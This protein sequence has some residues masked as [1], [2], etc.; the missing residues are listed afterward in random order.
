VAQCSFS[1]C[2]AKQNRFESGF[3]CDSFRSTPDL[4][5]KLVR[6]KEVLFEAKDCFATTILTATQIPHECLTVSIVHQP[7]GVALYFILDD[8]AILLFR[9]TA[10][11][12]FQHAPSR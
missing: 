1:K 9:M 4:L 10:G 7:V 5:W 6:L 2:I 11:F 12:D 8:S 3:E